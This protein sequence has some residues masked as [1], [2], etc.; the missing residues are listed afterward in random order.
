MA[1]CEG[2]GPAYA[3][4]P[5]WCVVPPPDGAAD[6]DGYFA[7]VNTTRDALAKLRAAEAAAGAA[8][9]GGAARP[10]FLGVGI[11]KPH[12]DWR[13]PQ[14]YL[15]MYPPSSVSLAAHPV[16]PAG[17]P[18]IAYHDTARSPSEHAQWWGWGYR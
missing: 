14:P 9:G 7:D 18:Q 3:P 13:V 17:M 5:R 11:R 1:S 8:T 12:L 6:G 10:F 2:S 15:D 16:A 4:H